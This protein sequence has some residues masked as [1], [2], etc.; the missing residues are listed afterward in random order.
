MSEQAMGSVNENDYSQTILD[1]QN[2]TQEIKENPRVDS[3]EIEPEKE[4][5]EHSP[6]DKREMDPVDQE[7]ASKRQYSEIEQE[8]I[9]K[10]WRPR[11][12]YKGNPDDF[13][14]A[15][16]FL[17]RTELYDKISNQNKVI[18]RLEE[19]M[20]EL[21]TLN[22][23]QHEMLLR[24]KADYILQQ[25]RAAIESGNVG[26]AEKFEEAYHNI[27]QNEPQPSH[28]TV[29]ETSSEP[30]PAAIEFARRNIGWFNEDSPENANMK[31]Y[32]I[33]KEIYLQKI[34]P[35][36][37]DERRLMETEKAVKDFFGHRFKNINRE[38]APQVAITDSQNYSVKEKGD[39][40]TFNQLPSKQKAI[41]RQ[42]ARY[43]GLSLD[44][45]AQQLHDMGEV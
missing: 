41:V 1:M 28:K 11:E 17:G 38:R 20:N 36:W 32:A 18:K 26:E 5:I 42:M 4:S 44:E 19:G 27:Y 34:Y 22:K 31:D 3:K 7:F 33:K 43:G 23:K 35:E 10:G 30:H 45:Y 6:P 16:E 25:K 39:K 2:A 29:P 8:A 12:E 13:R 9:S 40:F 15:S 14:S 37:S 21:T 24:E